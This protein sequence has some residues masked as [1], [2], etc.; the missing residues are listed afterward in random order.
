ML[1]DT[2][3]LRPATA[4]GAVGVDGKEPGEQPCERTRGQVATQ[5]PL[6][7]R[8]RQCARDSVRERKRRCL[9]HASR[10]RRSF[11]P[12]TMFARSA[13][14]GCAC[15]RLQRLSL[16][17]RNESE[18]RFFSFTR[19]VP[20]PTPAP[21]TWGAALDL[22]L[23]GRLEDLLLLRGRQSR[24]ERHTHHRPHL[25]SASRRQGSPRRAP[26]SVH[27]KRTLSRAQV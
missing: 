27:R 25:R 13:Q 4:P 10:D 2:T 3:T 23:R 14:S 11:A 22:G 21:P 15:S 26:P 20:E 9:R 16:F 18:P 6:S 8:A 7:T 12:R 5:R 17:S 19:A 24:V 1:V